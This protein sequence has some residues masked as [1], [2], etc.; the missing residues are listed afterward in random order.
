M[1]I[2]KTNQEQKA[3]NNAKQVQLIGD[4]SSQTSIETQNNSLIVYN[5]I[6]YSDI[7]S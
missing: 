4:N 5:G 2:S 7:V 3:G 6:Q 1:D